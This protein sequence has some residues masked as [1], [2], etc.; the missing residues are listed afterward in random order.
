MNPKFGDEN[1]GRWGLTVRGAGA[2]AWAW[3]VR[4]TT[5]AS[6]I[7]AA[8]KAS[9][10]SL[11]SVR[12]RSHGEWGEG[13]GTVAPVLPKQTVSIACLAPPAQ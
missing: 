6:G 8:A 9:S 5:A 1:G 12:G 3:G 7:V 13:G 2:G 10:S 11:P 4:A